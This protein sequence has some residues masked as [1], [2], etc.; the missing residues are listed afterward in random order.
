ML[1]RTRGT[2]NTAQSNSEFHRRIGI[3]IKKVSNLKRGTNMDKGKQALEK[4]D[5]FIV[6]FTIWCFDCYIKSRNSRFQLM[7]SMKNIIKGTRNQTIPRTEIRWKSLLHNLL[8]DTFPD[9]TKMKSKTKRIK[10]RQLPIPL[11]VYVFPA[12]VCPKA[13]TV[14]Q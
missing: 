13:K 6:D 1:L 10:K 14:A 9:S 11:I 5:L 2:T 12:E 8:L 4:W 3:R 7:D